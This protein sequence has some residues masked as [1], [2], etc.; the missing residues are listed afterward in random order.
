MT[1]PVVAP[2]TVVSNRTWAVADLEQ[3]PPGYRYEILEGVLYMAALPVWP[4][5]G[6][7]ENLQAILLPWVRSRNLGRVL[8]PQSGIDLT[9]RNYLDPDL[10]YLRP[11]QV[12]SMGQRPATAALAVEVLSPSNLRAPRES[13]EVL[14]RQAG[15]EEIWYVDYEARSLEVRRLGSE[16]YETTSVF[17]GGETVTSAQFPGL[18]FLLTAVWEGLEESD[19]P[20]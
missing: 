8:P 12:P 5:P 4:H 17:T 9:E 19:Q 2:T 14:F 20:S 11:T 15:V 10:I 1:H 16:G 6:I 13:R 3:M 7:I 18:E